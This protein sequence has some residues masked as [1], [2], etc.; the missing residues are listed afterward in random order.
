MRLEAFASRGNPEKIGIRTNISTENGKYI[1]NTSNILKT[2][3]FN[4]NKHK[5]TDI[6]AFGQYYLAK[7][8]ADIAVKA[9]EDTGIERIALSG[10]V[11]VNEYITKT[12]S[13]ELQS[14][15]LKV[16]YNTKVPP[17]D[18]G[19]ALGQACVALKHVM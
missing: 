8:V 2:L 18:G 5:K 3:L 6:A 12:I 14:T 11:F 7:G 4:K 13:K 19:T 15:G 1:L 9:S 17:G 10:G 16:L